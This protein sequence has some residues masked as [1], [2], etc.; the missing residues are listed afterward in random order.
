MGWIHAA[1]LK[2]RITQGLL[3]TKRYKS[4]L[5]HTT[6]ILQGRFFLPGVFEDYHLP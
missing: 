5:I 4:G 6:Q 1:P 2:A 3:G